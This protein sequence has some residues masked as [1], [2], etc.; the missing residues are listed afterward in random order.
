MITGSR[1][2]DFLSTLLKLYII[3]KKRSAV[4]GWERMIYTL[5][6]RRPQPPQYQPRDRKKRNGKR[7]EDYSR[8]RAAWANKEALALLLKPASPTQLKMGLARLFQRDTERGIKVLLYCKV[9]QRGG[10]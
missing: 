9:L 2:T 1:P 10:A 7:V 8:D 5:S 4:Q 6:V 3:I